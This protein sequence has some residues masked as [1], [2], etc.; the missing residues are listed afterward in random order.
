VVELRQNGKPDVIWP[1]DQRM[2]LIVCQNRR[3]DEAVVRWDGVVNFALLV[4]SAEGKSL[5]LY[6]RPI[7]QLSK[8]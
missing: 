4:L 5:F 8:I 1:D 7:Y 3:L 2:V 6:H